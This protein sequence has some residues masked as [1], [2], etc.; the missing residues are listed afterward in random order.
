VYAALGNHDSYLQAQD[1]PRA[2]LPDYIADE[3][4][5]NYE[6]V[7]RL[8]EHENWISAGVAKQA[9]A[10]YGAYSVAR[11]DGLRVITLNTDFWYR[12]N[13]FN[14]VNM[15]NPDPSGMLRFL[16]DELQAAEDAKERAWIVGH[17]LSGWDGSSSLTNP[18]NLFYQIVDRFS[19]HVIS[20]IL[21]GHTHEDLFTIFYANNGTIVAK[22]TAQTVAWVAPSISPMTNL[23]SGFRMYEVDAET[24]E[25]LDAHTW[26]SDVSAFSSLDHQGP[27]PTWRYEYD[28]REL[29]GSGIEWPQNAPLNATWWHM[30]TERMEGEPSLVQT[31]TENQG[32]QSVHSPACTS[33]ECVKAKICYLRSGSSAIGKHNCLQGYGTVQG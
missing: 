22:D 10:H 1:V 26:Y 7:S 16:T 9:R 8:W 11:K 14:Y 18:T 29:Y 2:H 23:N 5:W 21:F 13:Y 3:F 30:V 25:I 28:T 12:K 19:P 20:A 15:T 24:F 31:F 27:G 32:K 17:V 6:H 33:D 4:S